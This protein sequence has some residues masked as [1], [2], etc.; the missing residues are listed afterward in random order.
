MVAVWN[1]TADAMVKSDPNRY[2]YVNTPGFWR[3]I[4]Y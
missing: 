2:E 1:S 4:D 3:G